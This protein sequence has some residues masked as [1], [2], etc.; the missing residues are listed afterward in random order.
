MRR[1]EYI[2]IKVSKKEKEILKEK[3]KRRGLTLSAFIRYE[4]IN[5]E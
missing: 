5:K 2:M 4:L 3:A 1:E